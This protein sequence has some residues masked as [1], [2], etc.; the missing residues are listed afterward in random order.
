MKLH[1]HGI[2]LEHYVPGS[3]MALTL[4]VDKVS[5]ELER[6]GLSSNVSAMSR[7]YQCWSFCYSRVDLAGNHKGEGA[8]EGWSKNGGRGMAKQ[9][10]SKGGDENGRLL[11]LGNYVLQPRLEVPFKIFSEFLLSQFLQIY[12]TAVWFCTF[13]PKLGING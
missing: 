5:A 2:Y 7:Q 8:I 9:K 3:K 12:C 11:L 13:T 1:K 10:T 6:R 4:W